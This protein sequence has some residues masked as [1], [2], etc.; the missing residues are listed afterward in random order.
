M[1]FI[2]LD[3][4]MN[5]PSGRI[6]QIGAVVGDP[7]TGV[8]ID[9]FNAFVNP[10]ESITP[11]ITQLCAIN[12]TLI[13]EEGET[14]PEAYQRLKCFC[15]SY[16]TCKMPIQWGGGDSR[17]LYDDLLR[18]GVDVDRRFGVKL[19]DNAYVFGIRY[20]DAKQTMQEYLLKNHKSLQCGL[21]KAMTKLGLKFEGRKHRADVDAENT[22]NIYHRLLMGEV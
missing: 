18:V 13:K 12:N 19:N 9:R 14:L 16:Q 5:Q 15:D 6:I 11:F 1:N 10:E 22:F 7:I 3:L 2:S 8:I 17:C 20:F 4:E 21:S